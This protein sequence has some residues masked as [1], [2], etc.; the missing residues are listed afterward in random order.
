MG[1]LKPT[2]E[3]IYWESPGRGRAVCVI[4]VSEALPTH[5]ISLSTS[6]CLWSTPLEITG[7]SV[8]EYPGASLTENVLKNPF[9]WE[10]KHLLSPGQWQYSINSK[11]LN[12]GNQDMAE[13]CCKEQTRWGDIGGNGCGTRTWQKAAAEG[14]QGRGYRGAGSG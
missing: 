6:H 14:R 3:E 9:I 8:H 4:Q 1:K 11:Q 2:R 5:S 12:W 7:G 13:S 10:R